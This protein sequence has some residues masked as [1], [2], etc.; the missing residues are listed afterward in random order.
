MKEY[1]GTVVWLAV[2]Q[3]CLCQHHHKHVN[4]ALHDITVDVMAQGTGTFQ[5]LYGATVTHAVHNWRKCCYT[6]Y[7][8]SKN[9]WM[10]HFFPFFEAGSCYAAQGGL[11]L[12]LQPGVAWN[13]L[14][15]LGWLQIH[16][17]CALVS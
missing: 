13:L 8:Y 4:D 1:L 11:E 2:Q 3:V 14:C 6:E 10:A 17:P 7:G 5:L 16:D 9:H 12:A 15:S